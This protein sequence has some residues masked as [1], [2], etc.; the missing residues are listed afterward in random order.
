M[1]KLIFTGFVL[2]LLSACVAPINTTFESARML[3][4][5]ELEVAG[6][7]T[8]YTFSNDGESEAVNNNL[9]I[10][11]GY[12]FSEK[13]N[14]KARYEWLAPTDENGEGLN[15]IDIA[16]KFQILPKYIA[17]TLPLGLYFDEG[18]TEFVMSPKL[19]FTYPANDYFEVT[20]A[21][22]ADI[23]PEDEADVY[24]GVNLGLGLSTNLNRWAVRPEIG[25]MIDPDEDGTA[26]AY[27]VSIMTVLPTAKDKSAR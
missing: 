18:E 1:K 10:R 26:W 5:G 24:L 27:G 14:L 8:H 6:H 20:L 9:G 16:P 3:Q 22:K 21:T 13:F 4:K 2:S 17:G 15:Y 7:Y 19:I 12:G 23:F 25:W 11:A